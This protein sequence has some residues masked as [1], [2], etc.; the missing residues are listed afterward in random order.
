LKDLRVV[1][2]KDGKQAHYN[3]IL[4]G[5]FV[6]EFNGQVVMS[7][8]HFTELLEDT[9][10]RDVRYTVTFSTALP[11]SLETCYPLKLDFRRWV[12]AARATSLYYC[13]CGTAV[14]GMAP[15]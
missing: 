11:K 4:V 13:T 7:D 2:V 3:D 9:K 6:C 5:M 14:C 1:F 10:V 12:P 15:A 8:E